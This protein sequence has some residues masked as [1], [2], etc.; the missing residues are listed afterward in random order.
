M[1]HQILFISTNEPEKESLHTRFSWWK[2]C[3]RNL[4]RA[5]I[6]LIPSIF[7]KDF[8]HKNKNLPTAYLD[9]L[10][11]L[12]SF[13]VYFRHFL[14]PW[15]KDLD[16][17]YGQLSDD[18]HANLSFVKLPIIRLANSGPTV[19][20]FFIVSGFVT[21]HKPLK[22]TRRG[23]YNGLV[24]TLIPSVFRR[25]FRL[26]L[27]PIATTLFVAFAVY[28][29]LYQ[30]EYTRMP[31]SIPRHPERFDS[32]FL[33]LQD[34]SRFVL[35]DLINPWSWTSPKSEYDTHLWTISIQFRASMIVFLVLI[36]LAKTRPRVRTG[37]LVLLWIYCMQQDR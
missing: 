7:V 2:A 30:T 37:F 32:L 16:N 15:E 20:I 24:Q 5:V 3:H 22:L 12:F 29:G 8:Q 14:L 36:G 27:P 31:G 18:K 34:W 21:A 1:E 10:R 11:G 33:Q 13:L 19:M 6:F 23:D 26:F 35:A 25:A 28:F 4:S 17:G 9:G